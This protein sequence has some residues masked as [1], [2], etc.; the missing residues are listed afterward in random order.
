MYW[1]WIT[2]RTALEDAN[3]HLEQQAMYLFPERWARQDDASVDPDFED[4]EVVSDVGELDDFWD[5]F[6]KQS[7]SI[8]GGDVSRLF[9]DDEGWV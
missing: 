6:E 9:A 7:H 1:L 8:N 5:K 3:N 2:R 4:G